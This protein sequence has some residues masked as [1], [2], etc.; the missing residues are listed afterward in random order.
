MIMYS[1]K[2]TANLDI[3]KVSCISNTHKPLLIISTPKYFESSQFL[4]FHNFV[5]VPN[6]PIQITQSITLN[7]FQVKVVAP[8]SIIALIFTKHKVRSEYKTSQLRW[9][10]LLIVSIFEIH[11]TI[12]V[13]KPI[14]ASF[15]LFEEN[16]KWFVLSRVLFIFEFRLRI[17]FILLVV[18][19]CALIFYMGKPQIL[20]SIGTIL[21]PYSSR[22]FSKLIPQSQIILKLL[23]SKS[24]QFLI[25]SNQST[26]P[27]PTLIS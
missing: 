3:H 17:A 16:L 26:T 7:R 18:F 27:T 24:N 9:L 22:V 11:Y 5:I 21:F 2:F 6:Q 4:K 20:L 25:I 14:M 15:T 1:L 8:R 12:I 13:T 19:E 10:S 23:L